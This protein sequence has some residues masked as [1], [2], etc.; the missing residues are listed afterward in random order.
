MDAQPVPQP[1]PARSLNVLV[2]DD[3]VDGAMSMAL[4][5]RGDGHTVRVA[6]DGVE[7]LE[8]A[9]DHR[10]DAVLLDIGLPKG[11]DGLEVAR[12]LRKLPGFAQTLLVAM[13]G[14]GGD[15]D[16]AKSRTA[17]FDHHLTKPVDLDALAALFAR[18]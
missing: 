6:H 10:P 15:E 2:V 5:L 16:R 13:T 1:A 14:Y 7:A 4:V 8:I 18:L 11:L 3:N 12:R 9:R 17:G